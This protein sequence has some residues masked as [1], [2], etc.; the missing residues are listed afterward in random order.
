MF[1]KVIPKRSR[2]KLGKSIKLSPRFCGPFEITK[3]IGPMANELQLPIDWKIY[4]VFHISL[5]KKYVSDPTHTL[6]ELPCL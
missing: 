2:L 6:S 4:N 3:R 1:L 5:L